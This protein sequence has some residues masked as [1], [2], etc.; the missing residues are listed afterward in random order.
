MPI[1]CTTPA[2][3]KLLK[4]Q[5]TDPSILTLEISDTILYNGYLNLYVDPNSYQ[6]LADEGDTKY[7][8]TGSGS[9]LVNKLVR[10]GFNAKFDYDDPLLLKGVKRLV[11]YNLAN[12]LSTTIVDYVSPEDWDEEYTTRIGVIVPPIEHTGLPMSGGFSF[13]F[14]EKG[15]RY[16]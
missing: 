5:V 13:S 2:F 12:K 6:P 8:A 3:F 1:T 7:I 14:K 9:A 15:L 4:I 11:R 10:K 16:V